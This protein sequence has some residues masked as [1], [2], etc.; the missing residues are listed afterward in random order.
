MSDKMGWRLGNG[1]MTVRELIKLLEERPQ[2]S[3]ILVPAWNKHPTA[4]SGPCYTEQFAVV[5]S[6]NEKYLTLE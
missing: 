4:E 2:D 3:T 5:T 1:T 6:C